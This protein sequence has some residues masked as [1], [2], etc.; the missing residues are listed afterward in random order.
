M[1]VT[2]LLATETLGKHDLQG[3]KNLKI[4]FPAFLN[5]HKIKFLHF[6]HRGCCFYHVERCNKYF[7]SES[8]IHMSCMLKELR[9]VLVFSLVNEFSSSPWH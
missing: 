9:E 8:V 3:L 4:F 2:E 1:N 7:G 6:W 5:H